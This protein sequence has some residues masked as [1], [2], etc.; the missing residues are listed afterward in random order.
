MILKFAYLNMETS[1]ILSQVTEALLESLTHLEVPAL[2][3]AVRLRLSYVTV[4]LR[5][6]SS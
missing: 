5:R 4:Q 3:T 1:S 2:W 6:A